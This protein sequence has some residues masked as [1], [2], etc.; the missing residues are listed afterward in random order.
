MIYVYIY[1]YYK[2]HIFIHIYIYQPLTHETLE[3]PFNSWALYWWRYDFGGWFSHMKP[4]IRRYGGSAP[5]QGGFSGFGSWKSSQK[6][7]SGIVWLWL[8]RQWLLYSLELC[9]CPVISYIQGPK[10][11]CRATRIYNAL[12]MRKHEPW[13]LFQQAQNQNARFGG[14]RFRSMFHWLVSWASS[15]GVGFI[16]VYSFSLAVVDFLGLFVCWLPLQFLVVQILAKIIWNW[17][18]MS[19]QEKMHFDLMPKVPVMKHVFDGRGNK[20]VMILWMG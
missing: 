5:E 14:E 9:S 6:R 15:A 19:P 20:R 17:Q 10:N 3:N 1:T 7:I 8:P 16:W 2:K 12:G 13:L 11:V 18:V 4:K